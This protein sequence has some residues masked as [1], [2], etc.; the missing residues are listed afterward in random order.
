M[1]D[2]SQ[3]P[4]Y[5]PLLNYLEQ[6]GVDLSAAGSAERGLP[7]ASALEFLKLLEDRNVQVLGV[8]PW[9]RERA[10]YRCDA[11]GVLATTGGADTAEQARQHLFHLKLQAD[12]LVS[13]Q[14]R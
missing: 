4:T 11:L 2:R 13:V 5:A 8:E 7:L 14:Y 6:N 10:S 1:G 9:R 12:D 3:I